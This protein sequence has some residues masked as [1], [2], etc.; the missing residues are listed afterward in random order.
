MHHNPIR[1]HCPAVRSPH[2][3]NYTAERIRLKSCHPLPEAR[4]DNGA[5]P[6]SRPI[7]EGEKAPLPRSA[8]L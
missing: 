6:F 3:G 4:S 2:R 8:V 7:R 5:M 1:Y